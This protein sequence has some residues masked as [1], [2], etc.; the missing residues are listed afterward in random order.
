MVNFREDS[1]I[2]EVRGSLEGAIRELNK[3]F[4]ISRLKAELK[5]REHFL[6]RSERRK[7][8][9]RISAKRRMKEKK[10]EAKYQAKEVYHGR[11]GAIEKTSSGSGGGRKE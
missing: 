4:E 10:K 6:S 5:R 9:D 7:L 2:I 11:K 1:L 3:G 8:K